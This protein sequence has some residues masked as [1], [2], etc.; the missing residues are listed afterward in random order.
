MYTSPLVNLKPPV[1]I[2][3][4]TIFEYM[5]GSFFDKLVTFEA[6]P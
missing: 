1:H 5:I 6:Q 2:L 4:V 3:N